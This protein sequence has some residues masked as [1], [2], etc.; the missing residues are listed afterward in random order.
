MSQI[1]QKS[2]LKGCFWLL[3]KLTIITVV[4]LS[5]ILLMK[6][7]GNEEQ[8]RFW[9]I[10]VP[11]AMLFIL[12]S[13]LL[14]KTVTKTQEFEGTLVYWLIT[15]AA[16]M[17]INC[18]GIAMTNKY[19]FWIPVNS[20]TATEFIIYN[21][22]IDPVNRLSIAFCTTGVI[23]MIMTM[24]L[25]VTILVDTVEPYPIL[26]INISL[27]MHRPLVDR[28]PQY[29]SRPNLPNYNTALQHEVVERP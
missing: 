16:S 28:P 2:K 10:V 24:A 19:E 1:F 26:P 27:G 14:I 8:H 17:L 29:T 9:K 15:Y 7:L 12:N 21:M 5:I 6:D 20:K 23:C 22:N 11:Y 13:N 3:N 18:V 25:L 4:I